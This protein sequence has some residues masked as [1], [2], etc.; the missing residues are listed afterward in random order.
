MQG[1]VVDSDNKSVG[2]LAYG[3]ETIRMLLENLPPDQC[4]LIH[5]DFKIDNLVFEESS[6][7]VIGVLDWELS[8]LG[9][10]CSDLGK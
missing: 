7:R 4:T 10:P 3:E 8:T 6:S 9:H 5:G 2:D 1:A